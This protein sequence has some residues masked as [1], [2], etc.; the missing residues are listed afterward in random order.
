[1]VLPLVALVQELPMRLGTGDV[2]FGRAPD[3]IVVRMAGGAVAH[4]I[5]DRFEGLVNGSIW[6]IL[7]APRI[8]EA[9]S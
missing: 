8:D 6:L 1:M 4:H 2:I 7:R 9:L 5:G 3:P